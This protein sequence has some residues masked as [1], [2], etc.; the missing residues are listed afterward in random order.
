MLFFYFFKKGFHPTQVGVRMTEIQGWLSR[1][2]IRHEHEH[3]RRLLKMNGNR[4]SQSR[5]H[6]KT[7]AETLSKELFKL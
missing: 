3:F 6:R 5:N 4:F 1:K 2:Q 7:P